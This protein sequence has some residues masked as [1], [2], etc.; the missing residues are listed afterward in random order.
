LSGRL[1]GVALFCATFLKPEMLHIHRHVTGLRG[2]RP[3]VLTQKREGS[4]PV[5]TVEV[6]PRSPWR[7]LSRGVE[8]S[9]GRPWQ[10]TVGEAKRAVAVI[11]REN[12]VVLHVFFG[13]AAVH[14]LPLLRRAPV[15]VVVSFHGSDVAGSMVSPAYAEAV[16]EMFSLAAA[17]PCRSE[18]LAGA[19]GRLGCPAEK[20][21]LMRT[22]LPDLP[23]LQRRPP[24]D[25]AWRIA[26]A[27][28]LVAKKG[29]PTALRA[30]AE[31][32]RRFPKAT[33]TIAGEGPMEKELKSL[34]EELGLAGRVHF[35]G[36]LPQDALQ[37]LFRNAHIF[38]HPSETAGGDVEGVPNAMLEAMAGGLPVV[39]THHGGI[40][41]VVEDGVTGLLCPERDPAAVAT[42]L[43]RLADSPAFFEKLSARASASVNNQFSAA[44]QI[45]A[46]EGIYAE[47]I[48]LSSGRKPATPPQHHES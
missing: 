45:A 32:G 22:V 41:E 2:F 47:A 5:E 34:V 1:P 18:Q 15:P 26:Q 39:A 17:V 8:K 7:F 21:R 38:L 48:A 6:I 30:F 9:S 12:C 3:V 44:R 4:W 25:G 37:E 14:L 27:A 35:A 16:R 46:V 20:L 13:N 24:A 40:P 33:F 28:R 43:F 19:V 42:A 31:F 23:F 11:E 10:I 29:L 36:F